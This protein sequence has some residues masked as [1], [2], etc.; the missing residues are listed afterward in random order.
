MNFLARTALLLLF[1][2]GLLAQKVGVVKFS[3]IDSLMK[4]KSDTTYVINFW[5]TWWVPCV[6]ERPAFESLNSNHA[7]KKLKVILVSMDFKKQLEARV[8]PFVKERKMKSKVVLLNEPDYNS[9]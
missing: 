7:G 9:W 1:P 4:N 2:L 5:A 6:H 3:Y 8:I